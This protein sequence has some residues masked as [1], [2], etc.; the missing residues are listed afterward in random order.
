MI[1][2][3]MK[4]WKNC[5]TFLTILR[6]TSL[7]SNALKKGKIETKVYYSGGLP[8]YISF[9]IYTMPKHVLD[10]S[11]IIISAQKLS[12]LCIL[13]NTCS[14]NFYWVDQLKI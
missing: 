9:N 14:D 6:F 13:L 7:I 3:C 12:K 1:S 8:S 11:R 5:Y 2:T 4:M 10:E